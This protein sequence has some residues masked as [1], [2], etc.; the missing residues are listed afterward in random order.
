MKAVTAALA[1]AAP[2][3]GDASLDVIIAEAIRLGDRMW[4]TDEGNAIAQ[5]LYVLVRKHGDRI[6]PGSVSDMVR[7]AE[8]SSRV[9]MVALGILYDEFFPHTKSLDLPAL[10]LKTHPQVAYYCAFREYLG[11]GRQDFN[12]KGFTF[13]GLRFLEPEGFLNKWANR[14]ASAILDYVVP[15]EWP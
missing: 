13:A 8:S 10:F 5:Q 3:L 15:Q 4:G 6:S 11:A 2:T 9:G 1:A 12:P 7:R 14:G